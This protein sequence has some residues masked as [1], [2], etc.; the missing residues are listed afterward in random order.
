MLTK[1]KQ[2]LAIWLIKK[3]QR[4]GP[5][6]VCIM[7]NTYEISEAV[8]NPKHY[9]T[10]EFMARHIHVT[11]ED[12]VLDMGTGSG[13]QAITAARRASRVIALDI[14][15]EAARYAWKN[16]RAN[17]VGNIVSVIQGSLF[18]PLKGQPAFSVIF[19]T[20]P[21]MEGK[22]CTNFDHALFDPGKKLAEQFFRDAKE[23]IKPDGYIQMIYSSIADPEQVLRIS[24]Q[25]GWNH[26]LIATKKTYAE[27]FFIYKFR[28]D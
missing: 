11:P 15:P 23:H 21:Y 1:L 8:F 13:I 14:N 2:S 27:D 26:R 5:R 22:P 3:V 6:K 7:G 19:F 20:P 18:A 12:I 17:A 24:E 4:Y 9:Y 16:V 25:S 10:S 28:L